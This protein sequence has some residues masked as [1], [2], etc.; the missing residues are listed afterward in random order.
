MEIY[1]V[2]LYKCHWTGA[3]VQRPD[4]D[5]WAT[6]GSDKLSRDTR[7]SRIQEKIVMKTVRVKHVFFVGEG[8]G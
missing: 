7:R 2:D 5:L 3:L 8:G 1:S 4:V 6:S